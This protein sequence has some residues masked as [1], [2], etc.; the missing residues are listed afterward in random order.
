MA[1]L[2]KRPSL[3]YMYIRWIRCARRVLCTSALAHWLGVSLP[4]WR[5]VIPRTRARSYIVFAISNNIAPGV[6]RGT[7]A[8]GCLVQQLVTTTY[9][10]SLLF[11]YM[12]ISNGGHVHVARKR[13]LVARLEALGR[14]RAPVAQCSERCFCAVAPGGRTLS[15]ESVSRRR[16]ARLGWPL[17]D[18]ATQRDARSYAQA[19]VHPAVPSLN[20]SLRE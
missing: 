11:A 15:F 6:F 7:V 4:R 8:D 20:L 14:Y 10:R 17:V 5:G 16:R 12:R 19:T 13:M 2:D 3:P 1:R 9:K 18:K